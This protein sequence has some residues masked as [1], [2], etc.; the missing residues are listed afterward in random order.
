MLRAHVVQNTIR[1]K[2]LVRI[3]A[4]SSTAFQLAARRQG[5]LRF[6][7]EAHTKFEVSRSF[8]TTAFLLLIQQ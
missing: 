5:I 6:N 3:T 7:Y 4:P 1:H 2:I 8:L